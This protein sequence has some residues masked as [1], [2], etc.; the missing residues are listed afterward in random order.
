M[1]FTDGTERYF[2]PDDQVEIAADVTN[3]PPSSSVFVHETFGQVVA[4]SGATVVVESGGAVAVP[5]EINAGGVVDLMD[6]GAV[7][8]VDDRSRGRGRLAVRSR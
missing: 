6:G 2:N 7:T 8:G 1:K 4:D 3:L 5:I